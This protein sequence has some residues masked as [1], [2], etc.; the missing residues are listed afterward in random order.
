MPA[1]NDSPLPDFRFERHLMKI[2]HGPVAGIDEA[3]RGPWS[4]PVVAAAVILDPDNIPFGLNDSKKLTEKKRDELF[5]AI[6]A[7]AKIGVG[8]ADEKRIDRDNILQ[9][10]LWAMAEA[11]NTLSLS[12]AAALIDGNFRAPLGCPSETLIKGDARS[13]SIAAA[14]IVAKVTRDRIMV[15][16]AEKYPGYGWQRNKG[17]GTPEH[18]KGIEQ[19]GVTPHHRRSFRPVRLAI[20]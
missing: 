17:Y 6:Y 18:I 19:L 16:L 13:L 14:S 8:I 2:H 20:E 4:G 5:E 7:S 10:T 9:A 1:P 12:P 3:G 11:A 15:D